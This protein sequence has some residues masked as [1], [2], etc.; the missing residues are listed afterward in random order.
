MA[1][2]FLAELRQADGTLVA[3]RTLTSYTA[4]IT[5]RFDLTSGERAAITDW[6]TLQMWFSHNGT[7]GQ[8]V[9]TQAYLEYPAEPQGGT[10]AFSWVYFYNSKTNTWTD[11]TIDAASSDTNDVLRPFFRGSA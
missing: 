10:G 11:E 8:S 9:V 1:I 7:D 5:E 2:T 4:S 3:T 6:S